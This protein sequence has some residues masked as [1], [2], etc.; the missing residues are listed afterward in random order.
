M[1][2]NDYWRRSMELRNHGISRL[3]LSVAAAALLSVMLPGAL[4]ADT[5]VV[6]DPFSGT[7]G[8]LLS[9]GFYVTSYDGTN[10]GS[11]TLEYDSNSPRVYVTSLTANLGAYNGPIIGSTETIT[12]TLGS[13]STETL[14]TYNFGGVSVPFG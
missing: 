3:L 11:V 12:T 1:G 13:I 7:G 5:I 8:D 9:R 10:L 2:Q 14:V 4:R 6:S